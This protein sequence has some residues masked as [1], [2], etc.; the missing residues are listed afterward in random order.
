V[1]LRL[2][3]PASRYLRWK[4]APERGRAMPDPKQAS[5]IGKAR[6]FRLRANAGLV[7]SAL[8]H[9]TVLLAVV[10]FGTPR[11]LATAAPQPIV[12]DIVRPE[13]IAQVEATRSVAPESATK[14]APAQQQQAQRPEQPAQAQREQPRQT[15]GRSEPQRQQAQEQPQRQQAQEPPQGQQA[16]PSATGAAAPVFASLYPWPVAQPDVQLGDYRTFES[17]EKS[18]HHELAELKARLKQCWQPPALAGGRRLTA[19]LRVALR[20]DGSLAGAPELVEVSASPD[21]IALVASAKQALSA[22]GRF[23]FLP[24][25]SYD[26]WKALS[27]TFS[28]DDIAVATVTR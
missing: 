6:W 14:Q 5:V 24:A 18:G 17:L 15:Q 12:V 19:A 1:I 7:A 4:R 9:G 21:A 26:S 25:D 3:R 22:C 20:I 11:Q 8:A 2:F 13:E 10:L 27:L 16:Q 23:G 28:P